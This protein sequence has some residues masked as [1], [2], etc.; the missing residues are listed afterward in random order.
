MDGDRRSVTLYGLDPAAS[1]HVRVLAVICHGKSKPSPWVGVRT[2]RSVHSVDDDDAVHP[3]EAINDQ[4][5]T[6]YRI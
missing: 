5:G 4:L 1:Y 6:E 3:D 2:A